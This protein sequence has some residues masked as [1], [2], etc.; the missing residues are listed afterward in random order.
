MRSI[1]LMAL[2]TAGCAKKPGKYQMTQGTGGSAS[3][4][5]A[6]GD[7]MWAQR[8]DK[9]KLAEALRNY[10]KAFAEDGKN[11]RIAAKLVRGWYFMGDAHE[12][13]KSA[14]MEAWDKAV[15]FGQKCLSINDQYK[16]VLEKSGSK[17]EAVANS[18]KED[19]PCIYWSASSLGKWAKMPPNTFLRSSFFRAQRRPPSIPRQQPPPEAPRKRTRSPTTSGRSS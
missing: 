7:T 18:T 19:V 8:D 1:I 14:K 13:E 4:S 10:E 15:A 9:A 17:V 2:L 5:V 3:E 11:R 12:T 16:S 6:A